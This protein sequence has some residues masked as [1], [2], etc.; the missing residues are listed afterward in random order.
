MLNFQYISVLYGLLLLPLLAL[1]FVLV[2]R[3]KKKAK[4]ALGDDTLISQLTKQYS[5]RLFAAKFIIVLV[6]L[7]FAILAA[8]N[9]RRPSKSGKELKAGIDVMIAL[10]VSKSMWS[11][12]AKPTRLDRAKAFINQLIT[13]L[14]DNRAGLVIFAGKAYLQ[15]P[16]TSDAAASAIFVSNASPEAVPVQGTEIGEALSL[17][18]HSLNTKE[19]KYKA[20]VLISDGEDHDPKS[21]KVIQQLYDDGVIVETVGVGSPDGSP[22]MEPGSTEYKRDANGQTVISKLNEQELQAIAQK[23]GGEY[24][25][26]DDINATVNTVVTLLDGM[27]KKAIDAGQGERQYSSFYMFFLLPAFLMLLAEIFI[28]ERKKATV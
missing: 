6:A 24:H 21:E 17:C 1:L 25:H 19:K 11:Q 8:S 7:A 18:S 20:V 27:E 26:L 10:D 28:P 2:L 16:L 4:A 22:I 5:P 23:T 14:G 12:D 13:Q 3:W 15:M 9:P